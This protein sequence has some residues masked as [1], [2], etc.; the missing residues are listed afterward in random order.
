M[1]MEML[2]DQHGPII[3]VEEWEYGTIFTFA[4]R[5]QLNIEREVDE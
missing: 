1:N 4:D 2:I 3:D 5:Y